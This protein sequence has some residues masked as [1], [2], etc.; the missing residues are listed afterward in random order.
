MVLL[1]N[2]SNMDL[3]YNSELVE[4]IKKVKGTLRIQS[5]GGEMSVNQKASIPG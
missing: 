2:E 5:N 1:Y 4:D 3:F